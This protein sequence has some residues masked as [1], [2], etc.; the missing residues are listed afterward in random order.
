MGLIEQVTAVYLLNS[1]WQIPMLYAAGWLT[2]HLLHSAE[3]KTHHRVWVATLLLQ[4]ILPAADLS[5]MR[6]LLLSPDQSSGSSAGVSTHIGPAAMTAMQ[7]IHLPPIA[8]RLI[9]LAYALTVLAST[10]SLIR[11]LSRTRAIERDAEPLLLQG[12]AK[13]S[14]FYLNTIPPARLG[15]S[16]LIAGPVALGIVRPLILFPLHLI[17]ALDSFDLEAVMAHEIAHIRRHDFLK[18]L[19][20][21]IVTLPIAFHPVL[22]LTRAR[23]SETRELVCDQDAA[24]VLI[25][26]RSYAHSLLRLAALL[27]ANPP[28]KTHHAL[29]IAEA[30]IFER[31]IM[32]LTQTPIHT[33]M[34]RRILLASTAAVLAVATCTSAS[35]LRLRIA[36]PTGVLQNAI[37]VAAGDMQAAEKKQP[38]YPA[39]AKANHD[40]VDGP[41]VLSVHIGKDGLVR[42]LHVQKSLRPDYDA[43]ALEAVKDWHWTPYLLNGEPT[44]VETTV[45]VTYSS[46]N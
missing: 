3:S 16:A 38:V 1:F 5:R 29:G 25:G 15:T 27:T 7:L 46:N 20:Y 9:L 13:E 36:P 37:K 42:E 45:T 28:A 40:T 2:I 26:N 10:A 21:E 30:N 14:C 19:V 41:V 6:L 34:P 17:D 44:E 39:E 4:A 32:K 8:L 24:S 23:I 31:R 18:N 22:R 35:A 12:P 33:S 43:S 11:T